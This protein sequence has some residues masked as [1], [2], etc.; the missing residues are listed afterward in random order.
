MKSKLFVGILALALLLCQGIAFAEST[1]AVEAAQATAEDAI[2]G[3]GDSSDMMVQ[4]ENAASADELY[5]PAE[6]SEK[7]DVAAVAPE[8]SK[9]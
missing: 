9:M 3:G 5:A 6:E 1:E 7:A 4:D 8:T 2:A